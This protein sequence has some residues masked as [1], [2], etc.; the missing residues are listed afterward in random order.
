M[1]I[2]DGSTCRICEECGEHVEG[3][4]PCPTCL[5]VDM[6]IEHRKHQQTIFGTVPLGDA[7]LKVRVLANRKQKK[8]SK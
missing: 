7:Q 6:E 2:K 3:M 4:W 8:E 5:K 1:S